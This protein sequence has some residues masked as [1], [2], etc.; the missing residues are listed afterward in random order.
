MSAE[1]GK[2]HIDQSAAFQRLTDAIFFVPADIN[3]YALAATKPDDDHRIPFAESA[4]LTVHD[5]INGIVMG[6]NTD[7]NETTMEDLVFYMHDILDGAERSDAVQEAAVMSL[8]HNIPRFAQLLLDIDPNNPRHAACAA[9]I[10]LVH[11]RA[12]HER[13]DRTDPWKKDADAP[14]SRPPHETLFDDEEDDDNTY[15]TLPP[16][17]RR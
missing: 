7:H 5:F 6:L 15:G 12:L 16:R 14:T 4:K 17:P 2:T 13:I 3:P 11:N 8:R 10:H 9:L 1:Q